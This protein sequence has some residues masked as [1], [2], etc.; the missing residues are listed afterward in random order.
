LDKKN[1]KPARPLRVIV[2]DACRKN[3]AQQV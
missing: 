3:H 2:V 1:I